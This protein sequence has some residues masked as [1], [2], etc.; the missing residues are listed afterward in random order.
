M[1]GYAVAE[2]G[3]ESRPVSIFIDRL[4]CPNEKPVQAIILGAWVSPDGEGCNVKAVASSEV[5]WLPP[6]G[7]GK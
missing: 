5:F 3:G 1:T 2:L 7:A 4:R 6:S